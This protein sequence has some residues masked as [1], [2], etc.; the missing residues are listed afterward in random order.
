MGSNSG[1]IEFLGVG[2]DM[3]FEKLGAKGYVVCAVLLNFD[4]V[5]V[6]QVFE[7]FL[8]F[9]SLPRSK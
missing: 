3:C 4:A 9:H 6:G 2:L 5:L 7:S 1:E 8:G